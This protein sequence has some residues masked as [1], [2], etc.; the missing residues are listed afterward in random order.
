MN[1]SCRSLTAVFCAALALVGAAQERP[2]PPPPPAV[3][4]TAVPVEKPVV[5]TT[6]AGV[7]VRVVPIARGLSH[8]SGLVFLPDSRT[9]L[10]TERPGRLRIITD[11]VLDPHPVLELPKLNNVS[12][13][14]LHDLV[15]HP[16]FAT[17]HVLYLSY[18]K[19]GDRG[20]TLAVARARL[21]GNRL[22]DVKDIFVADAWAGEVG[23]YG[24]R[25]IF[26][27]DRLLYLAVGDRDDLVSTDDPRI[28]ME[29]QN[30]GNHIG[31]ILRLRDEGSVPPDNPFVTDPRAKAE[32]FTYGH[33]NPYGLAFHPQT[34]ALWEAEFGP[35]GGD[36]I[37]VLIAGHNYGWPLVSTGR[38]YTGTPV[39][40]QPWFRP[41]MEMPVFQWNPVINPANMI[42]YTG[43]KFAKWTNSPIVAGAGSKK[44]VQMTLTRGMVVSGDSML[45]ELD[46]RFRDVRQG[47]DQLLYLLTEGRSRGNNDTDGMLLRLEPE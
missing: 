19:D 31:K 28:R 1:G 12:L 14:G 40:D 24:G 11:G 13:G 30:L 21:D 7:R 22:A 32:I 36:E 29:A 42:F 8:P 46:V 25:M 34:G 44:V 15:L 5:L 6:E 33:R 38:N 43:R 18:S 9:M 4:L 16:D 39:S 35:R 26:G 20:V 17:N 3:P 2:K 45:R 41:G 10:L 23:T 47:P 27:P 37:N